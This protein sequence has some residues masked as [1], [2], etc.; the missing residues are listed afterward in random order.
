MRLA[1]S[2]VS[3]MM[4]MLPALAMAPLFTLWFGAT[5]RASILFIIFSV[6]FI[7]LLATANAVANLPAHLV[8]YPRTL[9][10][11]GW[12]L[13]TRVVTPAILPELRG[14]LVFGGLVAWTTVLA[15]EMYGLGSGLGYMLSDT[16]RFSQVDRMV[17]VALIF[18]VLALAT[19][20]LLGG[21]VNRLT[22]TC[23]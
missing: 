17:V 5:S 20:K 3:E 18:S 1:V 6:A 13:W 10:L 11:S 21:G 16:L 4:R 22:F 19:M 15:S 8:D 2:G 23:G 14:S 7:V 9:G 12:G